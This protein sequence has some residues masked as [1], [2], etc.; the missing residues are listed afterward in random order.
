MTWA[1][2]VVAIYAHRYVMFCWSVSW[3]FKTHV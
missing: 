3:L 2:V 1:C